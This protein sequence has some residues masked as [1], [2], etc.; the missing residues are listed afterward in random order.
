[1][2]RRLRTLT[3]LKEAF[4]F[5]KEIYRNGMRLISP[6]KP[7][8]V[9]LTL[10]TDFET[11]ASGEDWEVEEPEPARE[12]NFSQAIHALLLGYATKAKATDSGL[13]LCLTNAGE[14][15]SESPD[16]SLRHFPLTRRVYATYWL[17]LDANDKALSSTPLDDKA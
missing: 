4:T 1:M 9:P 8:Y 7:G 3:E 16:K 6:E 12:Y 2:R 11:L 10:W 17:L 13:V 15:V 14:L 5:K